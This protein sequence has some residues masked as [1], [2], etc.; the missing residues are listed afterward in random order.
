[1]NFKSTVAIALSIILLATSCR[2]NLDGS[3]KLVEQ[4]RPLQAI[5]GIENE[6]PFHVVI[7]KSTGYELTIH[8]EDNIISEVETIVVNG[9]LRVK[10]LRSNV[11]LTHGKITVKVKV[12]AISQLFMKGSGE[13]NSVESW[14]T[15]TA[16]LSV[17]GSGLIRVNMVTDRIKTVI[18][19]SGQVFL[20][21]STK[22]GEY[23]LSGSGNLHGYDLINYNATGSIS[24][25]A[26]C[27]LNVIQNLSANISGSGIIYYSGNPAKVDVAVSGSGKVVKL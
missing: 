26:R 4:S 25:S 9:I 27:E 11:Q 17:N 8:G 1:M 16:F 12:P 18:A 10:Y 23:I 15:G 24:G 20:S 14:Q 5:S 13:I 22:E 7:E 2:K 3:G 19:G 6:G 21:G